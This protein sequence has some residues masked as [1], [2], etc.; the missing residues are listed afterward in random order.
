MPDRMG[1]HAIKIS[2]IC[3]EDRARLAPIVKSRF[4]WDSHGLRH[5]CKVEVEK[6]EPFLPMVEFCEQTGTLDR[7]LYII[8]RAAQLRKLVTYKEI[9]R[10]I[11][12]PLADNWMYDPFTRKAIGHLLNPVLL[13]RYDKYVVCRPLIRA[14][15]YIFA[16]ERDEVDIAPTQY[17][18][19]PEVMTYGNDMSIKGYDHMMLSVFI[20]NREQ[21][22]SRAL[23][24]WEVRLLLGLRASDAV[25][26]G[27]FA[28][29]D[30]TVWLYNRGV[31]PGLL[32]FDRPERVGQLLHAWH[33]STTKV[34][35]YE[36]EM[37]MRGTQRFY[38]AIR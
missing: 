21:D 4:Q 32:Q 23:E 37:E 29:Q 1:Y 19:L 26:K 10:E 13:C 30:V 2:S 28:A 27:W 17:H 34:R 12:G 11:S 24:A 6:T 22:A 18:L 14:E 20:A 5:L 38:K 25:A 33:R 9:A 35:G 15:D 8:Y 7:T 36:L 16:I 31:S 3:A